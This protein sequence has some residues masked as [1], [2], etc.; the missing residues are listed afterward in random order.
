MAWVPGWPRTHSI[1]MPPSK[2]CESETRFGAK[3]LWQRPLAPTRKLDSQNTISPGAP[4][5]Q[6]IFHSFRYLL[7]SES[8]SPPSS[9]AKSFRYRCRH[10]PHRHRP[11]LLWLLLLNMARWVGD[12]GRYWALEGSSPLRSALMPGGPPAEL[13]IP[14]S[15]ESFAGTCHDRS[16]SEASCGGRG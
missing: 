1:H 12:A 8:S 7:P 2:H 4:L 3:D 16:V 9:K 15:G 11:W 6:N 14:V 10:F 13:W 5:L